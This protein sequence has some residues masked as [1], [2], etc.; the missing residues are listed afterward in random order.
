[1][2]HASPARSCYGTTDEWLACFA[3][4]RRYGSLPTM[5]RNSQELWMRFLGAASFRTSELG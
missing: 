2:K 3:D 1:M 4:G 5:K